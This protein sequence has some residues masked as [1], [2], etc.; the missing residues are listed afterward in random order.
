M[1]PKGCVNKSEFDKTIIAASIRVIG[2]SELK[3]ICAKEHEEIRRIYL[4]SI[5]TEQV[6]A[7]VTIPKTA[8]VADS[9]GCIAAPEMIEMHGS[10]IMVDDEITYSGECLIDWEKYDYVL[11][12]DKSNCYSFKK[13]WLII[14][15]TTCR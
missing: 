7:I 14:K 10:E 5:C 8:I 6:S 4:K 15:E 12:I 13:E 9:K 2:F 3:D 1:L 11:P